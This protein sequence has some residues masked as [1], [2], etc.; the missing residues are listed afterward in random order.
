MVDQPVVV[1]G[2]ILTSRDPNDL[3]E[4]SQGIEEYLKKNLSFC[5]SQEKSGGAPSFSVMESMEKTGTRNSV[6]K[7]CN[8]T[9]CTFGGPGMYPYSC[10]NCKGTGTVASNE[11]P[12]STDH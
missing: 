12:V 7:A 6:C 9:G 1:D 5:K 4:F 3:A 2:N 11:P 10:P 8:G